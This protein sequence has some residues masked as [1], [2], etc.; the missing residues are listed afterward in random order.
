[1]LV[2]VLFVLVFAFVFVFVS[3]TFEVKKVVL[4]PPEFGWGVVGFDMKVDRQ[5][6][7][8]SGQGQI[9]VPRDV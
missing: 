5:L 3:V 8:S 2:C 9:L 1:M 4:L 7:A 6:S